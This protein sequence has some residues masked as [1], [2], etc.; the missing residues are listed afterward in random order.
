LTRIF[1][2]VALWMLTTTKTTTNTCT[3]EASL[4]YDNDDFPER[5]EHQV[6][7]QDNENAREDHQEEQV[8]GSTVELLDQEPE[9]DEEEEEEEEEGEQEEQE[10]LEE[11]SPLV[12]EREIYVLSTLDSIDQLIELSKQEEVVQGRYPP[13]SLIFLHNRSCPHS[14]KLLHTLEQ[15]IM[16]LHVDIDLLQVDN[17]HWAVPVVGK[18]EVDDLYQTA[19][20]MGIPKLEVDQ[21]LALFHVTSVPKLVFLQDIV[22]GEAEPTTPIQQDHDGVEDDETNTMLPAQFLMLEYTGLQSNPSDLAD[23]LWHYIY[24]LQFGHSE[25]IHAARRMAKR[26]RRIVLMEEEKEGPSEDDKEERNDNT[27]FIGED[28]FLIAPPPMVF[29]DPSLLEELL[30]VHGRKILSPVSPA[31]DPHWYEPEKKALASLLDL[32]DGLG[33][34]DDSHDDPF[35]VVAQCHGNSKASPMYEYFDAVSNVLSLRRD[36]LFVILETSSCSDYVNGELL[37]DGSVVVYWLGRSWNLHPR[38]I[39]TPPPVITVVAE[40]QGHQPLSSSS[41]STS[42]TNFVTRHIT[43]SLMWMDRQVTAPIAFARHN[44]VHVVLFVNVHH[45]HHSGNVHEPSRQAVQRLRRVCQ[46]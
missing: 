15:A 9:S 17:P 38:A 4:A 41:V 3:V 33:L 18:V 11:S 20:A 1:L 5:K 37:E 45:F 16:L 29:T 6:V 31:L 10:P 13:L 26:E 14:M 19:Q 30:R 12:K 43:P 35:L 46:A 2:L 36:L 28:H 23:G 22:V 7:Q 32:Q 42:L 27:R 25:P 21:V 40:G 8:E 44:K 24:R 34:R 39:W